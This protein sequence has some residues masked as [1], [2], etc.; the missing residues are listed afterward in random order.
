MFN[1]LFSSFT[2]SETT[3]YADLL[4]FL[5]LSRPCFAFSFRSGDFSFT[6]SEAAFR[7]SFVFSTHLFPTFLDLS[8]TFPAALVVLGNFSLTF[9]VAFS[10]DSFNLPL[11]FLVDDLRDSRYLRAFEGFLWPSTAPA[12]APATAVPAATFATV[13]VGLSDFS[14]S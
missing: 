7:A 12:A 8:Q 11:T 6:F 4:A 1:F 5:T 2:F 14:Q 10:Q 13:E 3:E 9:F